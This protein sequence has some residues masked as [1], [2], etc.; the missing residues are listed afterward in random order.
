LRL[1]LDTHIMLWWALG[2]TR[3]SMTGREMIED[4]SNSCVVS[5]ASIWEYAI[6][7]ALGRA[8]PPGIGGAAYVSLIEDAGFALID[9]RSTHALG[10]ENLGAIHGDPFDR[11][12]VAQAKAEQLTLVTHDKTLAAYGDFVMVV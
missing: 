3:L 8:L 4:D 5:V 1:L 7:S 12:L 2:N 6:K 11:L 10:V 9:I